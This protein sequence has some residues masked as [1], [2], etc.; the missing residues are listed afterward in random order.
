MNAEI[1]KLAHSADHKHSVVAKA[2]TWSLSVSNVRKE[3][4]MQPY[5]VH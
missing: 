3:R 4:V 2:M 5:V 1:G